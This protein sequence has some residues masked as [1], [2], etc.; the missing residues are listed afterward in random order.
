MNFASISKTSRSAGTQQVD[1]QWTGLKDFVF[2]N[3]YK[4]IKTEKGNGI[5]P[6]LLNV[7]FQYC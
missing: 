2:E 6:A 5:N 7:A 4:K 3:L 1:H